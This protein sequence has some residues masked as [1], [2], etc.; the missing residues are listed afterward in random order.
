VL[1]W[2]L[3]HRS[4]VLMACGCMIAWAGCMLYFEFIGFTF[5]PASDRGQFEIS[6]EMP[7]GYSI[8]ETSR[9]SEVI[10]A[11]L[12]ELQKTGEV[13]HFVTAIGS[14]SALAARLDTD[15]AMGPEFGKVMVEL[16]Q[17]T[18]RKRHENEIISELRKKIKPLP[19]MKYRIDQV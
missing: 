19:G 8:E 2:S 7:L 9:A 4:V 17:A 11:P 1:R 16:V 3:H 10:T 18:N 5:F 14:S 13:V 6:F 12:R 15:P